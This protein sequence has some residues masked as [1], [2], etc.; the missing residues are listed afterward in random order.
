MDDAV[1]RYLD[2][3]PAE[4]RVLFDRLHALVMQ[5]YPDAETVISYQIPTYRVG[6][7]RLYVGVWKHGLS[8]YGWRQD[9]AADFAVR[10]ADLVG[11][12]G[13]VKLRPNDLQALS[14]AELLQLVDAALAE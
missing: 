3:V 14:D 9:R 11:A 13:T 2:A 7:R 10:H 12:K 5:A 8:V 4:H 1:R 6:A